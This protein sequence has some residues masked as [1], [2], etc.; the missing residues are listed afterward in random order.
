MVL[1]PKPVEI[2]FEELLQELPPDYHALAFEFKAFARSR[3]IKTPAQLLQVVMS[4]CGVDEVLREVAGNFTL[5]QERITDTA[6][7]KRLKACGPWLKAMLQRMLPGLDQLPGQLRFVIV[8][9]CIGAR[10]GRPR[11]GAS[12]ASGSGP[13]DTDPAVCGS[14]R[15]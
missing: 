5:L 3:K 2:T 7:H 12:A 8:V 10:A 1:P 9:R 4:Y 11:H 15:P 13:H 6:I 14:D